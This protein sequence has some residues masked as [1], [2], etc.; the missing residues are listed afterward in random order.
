MT[1]MNS[2]SYQPLEGTRP[3]A[4]AVD[5][6]EQRRFSLMLLTAFTVF[7]AFAQTV[8]MFEN[9]VNDSFFHNTT[10]QIVRFMF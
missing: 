10:E 6:L 9:R 1:D 5:K 8:G 2:V 3:V 4:S 7:A